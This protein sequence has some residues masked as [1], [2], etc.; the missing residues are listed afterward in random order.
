MTRYTNFGRKRTYVEATFDPHDDDLVEVPASTSALDT[1]DV[2]PQTQDESDKAPVET[3]R[4]RR[5]K[6]ATASETGVAVKTATD[7]PQGEESKKAVKSEKTKKALAKLKAKEKAKR[8]KTVADRAAAS[9]AR[10]LKRIAERHSN[11]T[12]FACRE[13]GHSA[14][15]CPTIQKDVDGARAGNSKTKNV[16]GICYRCGS[17][18]HTLARCRKPT[19]PENPLPFASCFVCSG[20]GHLAGSC[21]KNSG[22]GVYPNGGSCKLCGETTHL[23]KDC[24]LRK[25][26]VTAVAALLGT[27]HEAGADEDDFHTIRRKNVE[28][29][30]DERGE[31]RARKEAKVRAGALTGIVRSFG[32]APVKPKKVVNF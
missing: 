30:M 21:P 20:R 22:K 5:R 14:R 23:A 11:T 27:G 6:S 3:T 1:L 29:D 25:M 12:C 2:T 15:D 26:E 7:A 32:K 10:R 31:E 19:D 8:A 16:V 4:K 13:V 9:E 24:S 17:R 18:K 28:V